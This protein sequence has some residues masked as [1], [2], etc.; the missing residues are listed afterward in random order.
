MN[1]CNKRVAKL[2]SG[3]AISIEEVT[4]YESMFRKNDDE[5]AES[6]LKDRV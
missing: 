4:E 6:T 1:G 3:H 5:L 2:E